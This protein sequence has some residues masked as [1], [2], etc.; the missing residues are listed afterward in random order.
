MAAKHTR[1]DAVKRLPDVVRKLL[2]IGDPDELLVKVL[3]LCRELVGADKV[4]LMLVEGGDLV[5]HVTQGKSLRPDKRRLKIGA[6]GLTG[7]CAGHRKPV[8]VGDVK[9]DKR[10]VEAAKGTRSEADLPILAGGELLGVLNFESGKAGFFRAS[11]QELLELLALQIAVGLRLDEAHRHESRLS[12]EL[13]MLN[14]LSRAGTMMEPKAFLKRLVDVV[15]KTFECSYVAV[16]HGDYEK[17]QL[18]QIAQSSTVPMP[19]PPLSQPFTEGLMGQAFRLGETVNARDV[20]KEPSYADR[21][22]STRS[23]LDVP[24]RVGDRCLGIL[25]AQSVQLDA[26]S[27]DEVQTL[28]T[29]ARS[30]VPVLLQARVAALV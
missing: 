16:F 8:I 21:I 4:T 1:L 6:E 7:W 27:D 17:S 30:I 24:I 11:D 22:P 12:T 18:V 10:Y 2:S 28:E 25:D 19:D 13:G 29:L 26:F 20:R 23:E 3:G 15:M 14:H 5:E 9:K